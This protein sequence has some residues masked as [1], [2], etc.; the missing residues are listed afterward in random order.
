MPGELVLGADRQVDGDAA[1]RE[2]LLD[3]RERAV[4]VGAL[5]VEHVDEED[6][7]EAEVVGEVLD[8]RGADLEPHHG[9]D[10]DERALDDAQRAPGLALEAR[11]ARARRGG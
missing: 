7:R 1:R 8:P 6:A 3:L 9:V 2:L 4:E 11:V 5:A 10:D